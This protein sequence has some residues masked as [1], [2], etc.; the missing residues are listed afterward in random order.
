MTSEQ[1]QWV[2]A[3]LQS[4]ISVEAENGDPDD[5]INDAQHIVEQGWAQLTG[6]YR[7]STESYPWPAC[8]N[9]ATVHID[10]RLWAF[11]TRCLDRWIEVVANIDTVESAQLRSVRGLI[12]GQSQ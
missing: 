8:I 5:L 10:A 2:S 9:R 1:W 11:A 6:W 3:V 7:G 4:V 12:A